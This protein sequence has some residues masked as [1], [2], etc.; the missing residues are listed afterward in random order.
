MEG[1]PSIYYLWLR[2][3]PEELADATACSHPELPLPYALPAL[4]AEF[5]DYE[6]LT[7][8]A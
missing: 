2:E 5:S 8:T 1:D 7:R 4:G 3:H 6:D